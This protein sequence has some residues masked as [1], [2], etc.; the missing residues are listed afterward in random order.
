MRDFGGPDRMEGGE[1]KERLYRGSG[2]DLIDAQDPPIGKPSGKDEIF[3][4]PGR[5]QVLMNV[6]DKALPHDCELSGV[7]IS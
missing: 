4:G 2:A 1:R 5:D 6:K 7:G 3:C